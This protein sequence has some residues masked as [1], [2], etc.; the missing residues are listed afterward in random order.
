MSVSM[1]GDV[2]VYAWRVMSVPMHGDVC[3]Y[4]WRAMTVVYA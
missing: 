1:H 2:C 4:A 3:V